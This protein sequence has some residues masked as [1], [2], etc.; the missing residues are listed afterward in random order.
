MEI[1]DLFT[2][3]ITDLRDRTSR[4]LGTMHYDAL[5]IHSGT[6]A[7]YHA[8]DQEIAF[9]T[10][11]HFRHFTPLV[12]P[13]H[14]LILTPD[15]KPELIIVT[16][17]DFWYER[18]NN[19]EPFWANN[20]EITH[21]GT[22]KSAWDILAQK[23]KGKNSAFVGDES[24]AGTAQGHD[25]LPQNRNPKELLEKLDELRTVKSAYEVMCIEQA[26]RIS[27]VGHARAYDAFFAGGS[28]LD[29]HHAFLVGVKCAEVWLPYPAITALDEHSAVL[30]YQNKREKRDGGICLLDAGVSYQGYAADVTRTWASPKADGRFVSIISALDS[31]QKEL[32]AKVKPDVHTLELHYEAHKGIAHILKNH[33]IIYTEDDE[34]IRAGLT[35]PFFPHG[36]GHFLGIQVHDV[37]ASNT[38]NDNEELA[39]LFPKLRTVRKL[40]IGNVITIEPGIYFIPMLLKKLKESASSKLVNWELVQ[41]L[42]PSGGAR[43]ED[44]ILVTESGHRN[45]TRPY[46]ES[47]DR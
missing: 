30:H 8:D 35:N 12:G 43:I 37:G 29:I 23:V 39:E 11:P 28:E 46:F 36:L 9:R 21:V 14:I 5:V 22:A 10:L 13:H 18:A 47:L 40:E 2:A 33:D 34:A 7:L 31:L 15:E 26:N 17:E 44:D 27:A 3:H 45:L 42:T 1:N 19:V 38:E 16:P 41:A 20:F 24:S 4:L 32:C 25:I 6:L